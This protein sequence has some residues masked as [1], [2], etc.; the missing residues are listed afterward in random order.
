[1]GAAP[2]ICTTVLLAPFA[3]QNRDP[4]PFPPPIRLW[5]QVDLQAMA[6]VH[7]I[8]QQKK[9]HV[10]RLVSKETVE[11]RILMRAEKKLYLDKMVRTRK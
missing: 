2:C 6:R 7:R 11:E 5:P 8:G 1:M 9:V 3:G 10:Y 4:V